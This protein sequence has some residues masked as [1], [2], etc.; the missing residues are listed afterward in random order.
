MSSIDERVV[1]MK[2]DNAQFTKGV[3]E[4]NQSLEKLKQGLNLDAS[5]KSLQGLQDAGSRF[6]LANIASGVQ[7]LS[8]KFTA[9]GVVGVTALVNITNQAVNAGMAFAKSLT[10]DPI[11]DGFGEYEQKMG[12]IQTILANTA[13]HGTSLDQVKASLEE[14]NA[15]SDKTIYN[16]GDMTRNIGMFTNAGI[17]LED[18]TAMIKGFS[19]EA[20]MSG[21]NAQQAAGAAYQLSQA[22]SKGKVTL[23]DWRS[24]TNA[25]MGNKNM[26]LGLIDIAN[27]MGT[28]KKSGVSAKTATEDFNGSLEKGWLSADVMTTYLK[29]QAGEMDAAKMKTIGLTDAQIENFS[30]MQKIAE[31]SATK[32][33]TWT[34]LVGT[35]KESV[36]STWATTFELLLGDFNEATDLFT[37]INDTLG[38]M[39]GKAGDARN[40]LIKEWVKLGG[41][42]EVINGISSLFTSVVSVAKVIGEAFREIFP[43][44]TAQTLMDITH[45]FKQFIDGLK[46]GPVQLDLIKRTFKGVFAVFDIGWLIIQKVWGVFERLFKSMD[47]GGTSILQITARIGDF[48]VKVRDT[49]V[50][51]EKLNDFFFKFGEAVKIPIKFITELIGKI[52]ALMDQLPKLFDKV[53]SWKPDFG[54]FGQAVDNLMQGIAKLKPTGESIKALWEGLINVFKKA[55]EIGQQM[56]GRIGDAFKALGSGMQDATKGV[57]FNMILGI[58][59]VG[60]G[61]A[62]FMGIIKVIKKFKDGVVDAIESIGQGGGLLDTIKEAFG[63]LTDTLSNMQQTLKASTLILLAGAIALLAGA[64]LTLSKIDAAKLPAVLAAMTVMMTQLSVAL[65]VLDKMTIGASVGNMLAIGGAMVLLAIAIKILASALE[66]M[67]KLSWDGILKGLTAVTGMLLGL[68]VAARIM[69]TQNGTMIQTGI[70]LMGVAIAIKILASACADFSK[71]SWDEIARGLTGVGTVL[72]ALALFTRLAK[73]NKGAMAQAGG[74]ILLG[75]ALKIMAS[76][77]DDFAKLNAGTIQQGLGALTAVLAVL[78]GF[79]QIVKPAGM[80]STATAMVILGAALKI[81]ATAVQ[82]FGNISW[83]VIG[84]G[85]AGMAGAL[86]SIGVA[87]RIMPGDMLVKA[88]ALVVVA[89]ALEILADVLKKMGGMSIE[90]IAKSL[91]TLAVGLMLIATALMVMEGALPGAAALIVASGALVLLANVLQTLGGMSIEQIVTGLATLAAALTLLGVAALILTPVIPALM[92]LGIAIG[93]LGAGAALAGV[94]MLAFAAGLTILAA[95]GAGAATVLIAVVTGLLGL[96]PYA[97]TQVG[98][99]IV[100]LAQTLGNNVQTFIDLGVKLLT[101]LLDGLRTVLPNVISFVVDMIMMLLNFIANNIQNFVDVGMRI[102]VGFINGIAGQIGNV[103]NAAVNLIVNFLNGIANNIGRII[104]AGANI[105]IAFIQGIGRQAGR[106]AQEGYNTIITFVNSLAD[107]IRSNTARMNAAGLNLAS[108][109]IDGMTSGIRNG[110]SLVAN[111]AR[112]VAQGALDTVKSWLG[113]HSPSR[114]FRKLGEFSSEGLAIGIAAYGKHVDAASEGVAKSA[115]NTMSDTLARLDAEM[116]QHMALNPV[117]TPVLDLSS[118]QNEASR[119]GTMITPPSLDLSTSYARA[120]TLMAQAKANQQSD[121]NGGSGDQ[122]PATSLTF[123]QNNYSPKAISPAE[124]YRNTKNQISKAKEV[125]IK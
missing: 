98:L 3:S 110:I 94:G 59:G 69:S 77:V 42:T 65:A 75:V 54:P 102:I 33:R 55:L 64:M 5:A 26:Q 124:T 119:L 17:K 53:K 56:A 79:T 40:N 43:P 121:P 116:D 90:E 4:T 70:A 107:T 62:G 45:K 8:S 21:T 58:L 2:F 86:V 95:A 35:M 22:M 99:A 76:A 83:E 50:N 25:S 122:P 66:D 81:M 52:P 18:A 27:A 117:I 19:N 11:M 105:I 92:G 112:N 74:L 30:K 9:L 91:S 6:S 87:M 67:S 12:S 85:L 103:V 48:L 47:G 71:L 123:V 23:E 14:L 31:E 34:Q 108:A 57:D 24:L 80:I 115:L 104:E 89:G 73:V 39:I 84:R 125:L 101:G 118:V 16:F 10:L 106:L 29:I 1:A 15:Y 100:A 96:L 120:A 7:D 20:A 46:P 68:S 111:A 60:V 38:P 41:R 72:G 36:G 113:I 61:G 28:L 44:I 32:V 114:E 51:S 82:D 88:A 49:L 109:I 93:L 37:K 97:F 78:A 13:R 63:G